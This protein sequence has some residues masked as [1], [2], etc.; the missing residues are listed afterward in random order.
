MQEN[1]E[2][3]HFQNYQFDRYLGVCPTTR[4]ANTIS[5]AFETAPSR[6]GIYLVDYFMKKLRGKQRLISDK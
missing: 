3:T 4:T 5:S 1:D 2:D 6:D